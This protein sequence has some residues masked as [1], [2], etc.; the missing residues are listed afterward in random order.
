MMEIAF[1]STQL[2]SQLT[3][4]FDHFPIIRS[5]LQGGEAVFS[6]NSR[7]KQLAR[8]LLILSG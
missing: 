6:G 1:F 8:D 4:Y 2:T 5:P 7:G 3:I